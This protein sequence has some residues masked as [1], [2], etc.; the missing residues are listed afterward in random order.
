M[1]VEL[2]AN[3]PAEY[4]ELESD[5]DGAS[6]TTEAASSEEPVQEPVQEEA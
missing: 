3:C 1:L 2:E 5:Y 4:A 6:S